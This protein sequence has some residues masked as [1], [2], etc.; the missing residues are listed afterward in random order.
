MQV[1]NSIYI[2]FEIKHQIDGY[3]SFHKCRNDGYGSVQSTI[4]LTPIWRLY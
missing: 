4:P 2:K 1:Q 3:T